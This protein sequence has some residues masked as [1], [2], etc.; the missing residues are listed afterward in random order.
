MRLNSR[1]SQEPHKLLAQLVEHPRA[2]P[3]QLAPDG[4]AFPPGGRVNVP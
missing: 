4:P 2:I 3:L 1:S